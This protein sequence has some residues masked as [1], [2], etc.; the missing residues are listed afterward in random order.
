MATVT[1]RV[2]APALKGQG[3]KVTLDS[4]DTEDTL[5]GITA[6]DTVTADTSTKTGVVYSV[7][8]E[9]NS[10]IV[11]PLMDNDYFDDTTAGVLAVGDTLTV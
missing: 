10:F 7:D 4:T 11:S 5:S 3:V 6:G 2:A 1:N 9:G 8:Y